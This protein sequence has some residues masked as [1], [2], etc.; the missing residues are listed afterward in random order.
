MR[1]STLSPGLAGVASGD[2][3]QCGVCFNFYE[4]ADPNTLEYYVHLHLSPEEVVDELTVPALHAYLV[5]VLK[6]RWPDQLLLKHG[7]EHVQSTLRQATALYGLAFKKGGI[8]NPPAYFRWLLRQPAL[9]DDP[10]EN[11][12]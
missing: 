9:M 2:F 3:Q 8:K 7:V 5:A 1:C 6:E 11:P 4:P 12:F 10:K